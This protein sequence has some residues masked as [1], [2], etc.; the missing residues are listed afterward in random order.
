MGKASE[1]R[2]LIKPD[3]VGYVVM[4]TRPPRGATALTGLVDGLDHHRF[5]AIASEML[6]RLRAQRS[7]ALKTSVHIVIRPRDVDLGVGEW[8]EIIDAL[9]PR[10]AKWLGRLN[11]EG[12]V[13]ADAIYSC[14]GPA[15][16]LYSRYESVERVD[17]TVVTISDFLEVLWNT[18]ASEA[19]KLLDPIG[20]VVYRI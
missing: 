18:V 2:R 1:A 11:A 17:G 15:M 9:P 19:L 3:G 16:E 4:L 6:H 10:I 14:I 20:E 13:G 12:V 7:A 5:L 8:G